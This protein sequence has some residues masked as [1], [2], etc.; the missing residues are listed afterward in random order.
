MNTIA[1]N[2]SKKNNSPK[3]DIKVNRE[4][5]EKGNLIRFD[6]V[7]SYSWSGDTT[8]Q[9]SV[10]PKDLQN[11]L[12]DQ[13]NILPDSTFFGDSL[14]KDFDPL[15]GPFNGKQ[16]SLL[17]KKFG[18]ERHF[19]SLDLKNDSLAMNFN[20]IDDFLNNFMGINKDSISSK[21]PGKQ[22]QNS[23]SGSMD[24]LLKILQKQMQ[25]MEEQQQEFFRE[26][27]KLKKL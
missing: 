11:L 24:D 23:P 26:Q 15:F 1:Q 22:F 10:L 13:F 3:K 8:M 27:P 19:K 18:M 7:Y 17:M 20:G 4:Y 12:G 14:F 5:D 2:E 6:S 16:D 9:N 25:E 21:N